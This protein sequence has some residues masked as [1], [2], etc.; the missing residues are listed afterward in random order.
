MRIR[1]LLIGLNDHHLEHIESF[2]KNKDILIVGVCDANEAMA[3]NISALFDNCPYYTDYVKA[4]DACEADSVFICLPH[5]LYY[6]AVKK[7]LHKGLHI[8]KEKPLAMTIQESR[9][10]ASTLSTK[11]LSLIVVSQRRFHFTYRKAKELLSTIGKPKLAILSY[12]LSRYA[13]GWRMFGRFSGGGVI[14]DSGY[15]F[16]DLMVFLFGKPN[17]VTSTMQIA[18]IGDGHD[19]EDNAV[20]TFKYSA[21]F[22]A[23][24]ILSREAKQKEESIIVYGESGTLSVNRTSLTIDYS[25]S[26]DSIMIEANKDWNLAFDNQLQHFVEAV[27]SKTNPLTD[28]KTTFINSS[29][30]HAS[31]VSAKSS[32]TI[33]V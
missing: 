26:R 6:P 23:N 3:V 32:K 24:I 33:L 13:E 10:I 31:Y 1:M 5:F 19:T 4:I 15:H 20:L 17:S 7:A 16:I 2:K 29:I 25:D 8:F 14:L 28:F 18:P 12:L 22:V 21:D 30:I 11:K 9:S 27:M